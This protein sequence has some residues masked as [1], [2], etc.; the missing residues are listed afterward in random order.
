MAKWNFKVCLQ[1][2]ENEKVKSEGR[3][4]FTKIKL[5]LAQNLDQGRRLTQA[6][7]VQEPNRA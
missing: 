5:L 4:Y 3:E 1:D 2:H 7:N 6:V